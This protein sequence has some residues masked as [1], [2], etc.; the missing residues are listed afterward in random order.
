MYMS[1]KKFQEILKEAKYIKIYSDTFKWVSVDKQE[2]QNLI[3]QM[4]DDGRFSK[5]SEPITCFYNPHSKT[6]FLHPC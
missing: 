6:I 5:G 4:Q 2:I 1:F 3:T